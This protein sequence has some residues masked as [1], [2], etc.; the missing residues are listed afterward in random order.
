ML[1]LYR[2]IENKKINTIYSEIISNKQESI[3]ILRV[4]AHINIHLISIDLVLKLSITDSNMET[5][6]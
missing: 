4:T 2:S 1:N 3:L 6:L 5:T